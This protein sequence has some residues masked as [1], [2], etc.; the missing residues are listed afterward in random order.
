[1]LR[2]IAAHSTRCS[3][4]GY[5]FA[6]VVGVGRWNVATAH[7]SEGVIVNEPTIQSL[8][9]MCRWSASANRNA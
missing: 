7:L 6:L 3:V 1:M 8:T 9:A 5:L 2:S 4:A